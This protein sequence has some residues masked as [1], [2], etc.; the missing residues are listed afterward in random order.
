MK[1]NDEKRIVFLKIEANDIDIELLEIKL[2]ELK[3]YIKYINKHSSG[4]EISKKI[5][6]REGSTLLEI[7]INNLPVIFDTVEI[8]N[9]LLLNSKYFLNKKKAEKYFSQNQNEYALY[10]DELRV[11]HNRKTIKITSGDKEVTIID[12]E[13]AKLLKTKSNIDDE[14][15]SSEILASD[16]IDIIY[17]PDFDN[18]YIIDSKTSSNIA[19]SHNLYERISN[20]NILKESKENQQLQFYRLEY[21]PNDNIEK[22]LSHGFYNERKIKEIKYSPEEKER[23]KPNEYELNKDIKYIKI[24]ADIY[25]ERHG[26]NGEYEYKIYVKKIK[27]YERSDHPEAD[28][29]NNDYF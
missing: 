7:I 11:E 27:S 6:V 28:K 26:Q 16:N 5:T 23:W 29:K 19:N 4:Y 21:D 3:K 8:T 17:F 25:Y 22:T 10:E 9:S 24:I 18:S 20:P 1:N 2:R 13:M 15:R 12:E 14:V